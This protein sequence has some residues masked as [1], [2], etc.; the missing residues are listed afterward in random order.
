MKGK[1][2]K[3]APTYIA[4]EAPAGDKYVCG[5]CGYEYN[6]E[7]PFEELPADYVC[8]VCKQ[9]KSVFVKK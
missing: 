5:V 3:A 4:E 9:P 8:P 2:P 6:G 7:V 1:S